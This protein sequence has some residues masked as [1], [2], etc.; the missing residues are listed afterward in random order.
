MVCTA[1][2]LLI[3]DNRMPWL[4]DPSLTDVELLPCNFELNVIIFQRFDKELEI[5]SMIIVY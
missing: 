2:L 4:D 1:Q 3:C 5:S